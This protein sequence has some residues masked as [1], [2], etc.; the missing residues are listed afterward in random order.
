M[1]S[2]RGR[3]H[4]G[5]KKESEH[6]KWR[7]DTPISGPKWD[8]HHSWRFRKPFL[9]SLCSSFQNSGAKFTKTAAD[10]SERLLTKPNYCNKEML[11]FLH[12]GCFSLDCGF[13]WLNI[14]K[15]YFLSS[16]WDLAEQRPLFW[17]NAPAHVLTRLYRWLN[18]KIKTF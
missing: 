15:R 6:S 11:H 7:R 16:I 4:G 13:E 1:C 14:T 9:S 12:S 8:N 5:K 18:L 17:L 3:G 10:V 2:D